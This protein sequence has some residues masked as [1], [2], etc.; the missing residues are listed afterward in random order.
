MA[1]HRIISSPNPRHAA[2]SFILGESP[3]EVV[4]KNCQFIWDSRGL[5]DTASDDQVAVFG[6]KGTIITQENE[7]LQFHLRHC[8][9]FTPEPRYRLHAAVEETP[10]GLVGELDLRNQ[11]MTFG[12]DWIL[13]QSCVL[14]LTE[15]V[16]VL[17]VEKAMRIFLSIC[18]VH[19]Y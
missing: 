8:L 15:Q 4:W 7:L 9:D 1:G 18:G 17:G 6:A 14:E 13:F 2:L 19:G 11:K 5:V 10:G 3:N 12:D 16:K